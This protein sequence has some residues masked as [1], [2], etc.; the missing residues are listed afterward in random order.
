MLVIIRN[1]KRLQAQFISSPT[2]VVEDPISDIENAILATYLPSE[3]HVPETEAPLPPSLV[4]P[5]AAL[6]YIE[7]LLRF[8]LQGDST[9]NTTELQ[10]VLK[11]EKKRIE[12]LE[13]ERRRQHV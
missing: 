2:E 10:D 8:S 6:S 12:I 9:A 11:R 7:G 4:T 13:V 1:A 3:A 5:H